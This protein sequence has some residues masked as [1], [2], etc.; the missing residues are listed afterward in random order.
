MTGTRGFDHKPTSVLDAYYFRLALAGLTDR[1]DVTLST[2][3]KGVCLFLLCFA[4]SAIY[5]IIKRQLRGFGILSRITSC[6]ARMATARVFLLPPQSLKLRNKNDT[7]RWA[8]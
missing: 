7:A 1:V 2:A 6:M 8:I 3:V 5:A 4:H